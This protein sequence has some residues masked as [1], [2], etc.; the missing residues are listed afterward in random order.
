MAVKNRNRENQTAWSS[1][2]RFRGR[3]K[4][5]RTAKRPGVDRG[6][7]LGAG[8]MLREADRERADCREVA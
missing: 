3:R 1:P 4:D 2:S 8:R 7:E 5:G 6:W